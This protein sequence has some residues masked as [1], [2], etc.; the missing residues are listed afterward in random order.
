MDCETEPIEEEESRTNTFHV[1]GTHNPIIGDHTTVNQNTDNITV[2]NYFFSINH[3]DCTNG[4]H[5]LINYK[6]MHTL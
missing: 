5:L 2:T 3:P 6:N 1:H 4:M